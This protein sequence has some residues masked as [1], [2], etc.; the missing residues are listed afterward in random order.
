MKRLITILAGCLI[1]ST[2]FAVDVTISMNADQA[3][4]VK[5]VIDT[6]YPIELDADGTQVRSYQAQFKKIVVDRWTRD[7]NRLQV[8]KLRDGYV[9]ETN[10]VS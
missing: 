1:A 10:I 6:M 9:Q 3:N 8:I 5:E 2:A 4:K 7:Y